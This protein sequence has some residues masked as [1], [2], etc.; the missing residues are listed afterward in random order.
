MG[1]GMTADLV[2]FFCLPFDHWD[3]DMKLFQIQ[4][5]GGEHQC[6]THWKEVQ[7]ITLQISMLWHTATRHKF[8]VKCARICNLVNGT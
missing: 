4:V 3:L 2:T 7:R 6:C 5:F 8:M 1:W